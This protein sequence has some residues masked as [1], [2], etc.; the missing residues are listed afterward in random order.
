[1]RQLTRVATPLLCAFLAIYAGDTAAQSIPSR[2]RVIAANIGIGAIAGGVSSLIRGKPIARGLIGGAAGG[3]IVFSGK[4]LVGQ[5]RSAT[6]WIGRATVDLGSSV[7]TNTSSGEE[8]FRT[9]ALAVGPFH[10]TTGSKFIPERI[11]VDLPTLIAATYFTT[12]KGSAFELR[13][14]L[15]RN[16]LVVVREPGQ[17]NRAIAGTLYL[18]RGVTIDGR[19][20]ELTHVAQSDMLGTIVSEPIERWA[21]SRTGWGKT[22]HRF[23]DL[24]VAYPLWAVANRQLEHEKR[25]WEAEARYFAKGC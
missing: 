7:I 15:R 14:S 10:V 8:P 4:C 18:S 20:H 25:P 12:R 22:L 11:S 2:S 6:D 1:M 17:G 13:E 23:I 3:L 16:A 24:G 9:I 19:A 5:G 21:L